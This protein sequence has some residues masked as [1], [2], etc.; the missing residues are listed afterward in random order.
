[1]IQLNLETINGA[2]HVELFCECHYPT[3]HIWFD[4]SYSISV[5]CNCSVRHNN[6]MHYYVAT[7]VHWYS[8][9]SQ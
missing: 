3:H 2:C 5:S 6:I 9:D 8:C 1:M 7:S 4:Y